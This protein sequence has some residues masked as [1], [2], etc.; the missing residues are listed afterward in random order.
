M[1][2]AK[3]GLGVQQFIL[4]FRFLIQA[5]SPYAQA[6]T[7]LLL[8]EIVEDGVRNYCSVTSDM[9]PLD[10]VRVCTG[11]SPQPETFYRKIAGTR[12]GL[13]GRSKR[14][15][16]RQTAKKTRKDVSSPEATANS[17]D[18]RGHP[19]LAKRATI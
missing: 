15:M 12:K 1:A 10:V 16:K 7:L 19:R 13:N 17:R 3:P 8:G 6:S 4:D 5:S 14:R 2:L 18:A 11:G 9:Q